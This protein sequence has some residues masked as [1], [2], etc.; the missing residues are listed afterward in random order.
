MVDWTQ[1]PVE[2]Q[3]LQQA[4]QYMAGRQQEVEQA[5]QAS[6]SSKSV[7][8]P[9]YRPP[10]A[11]FGL[12]ELGGLAGAVLGGAAGVPFG[13]A[14]V[15]GGSALGAGIGGAAGEATA[16]M[17]GDEKFS[18]SLITKAGL[19][20][21]AWDAGGNLVIKGAA[22]TLRFG[23]DKL[24]FTQK[25]IPDANQAAQQ[26]LEK[27]QSS[28]PLAART[29]SN[30]DA[31]LEGL[32]YTP[33]T[34][35]IFK[36]KQ[37]EIQ[38]ALRA[39]QK[40]VLKQFTTSPE[41]ETALRSGTSAQRASGE[42]L[43]NFIKQGEQALGEA[44]RPE[45]QKIFSAAPRTN[46]IETTTGGMPKVSTFGLNA[47]AS[48]QLADPLALTKGQES[49]LKEIKSLPSSVDFDTLHRIRSR[50]LAE[51]RDKY[52]ANGTEKDSLA[53]KTITSL[54]S[55]I[56][57]ALDFSADKTLPRELLNQY[58]QVTKTYREGIQ[59][60]QT[61]AVQKAL[62][63]NPEEVGATLF[64]AGNETPIQQLYKSVAAAGTLSGKSSKE[65]LDSLRVGYLDA[66]T[67]TPENMLKFAKDLEQNKNMQNTFNLLFGGT[68]QKDAIMAMNEAAKK[69]LIE[70]S[71]QPGLRGRT[72]YAIGG[73]GAAGSTVALAYAF[74]LSPEQ[75][76][77]AKDNLIG[78]G[79]SGASLVLSQRQLAK[80]M[81]DP[82]GAKAV[83]YLSNAKDRLKSPSAFT[84]LVI[85]P[86]NN[87]LGPSE[88]ELFTPTGNLN[89]SDV[90]VEK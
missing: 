17:L 69:G 88:T 35:D 9:D 34:F 20:E 67:H 10:R 62:E 16:Q 41:F 73:L 13:P 39:G 46:L 4:E 30:F 47:W 25:D 84:K 33:A 38:D 6:E 60:L 87:I 83:T 77:R 11:A 31:A 56:D 37:Q 36:R 53:S 28:L 14:G 89:W 8:S 27:Q 63:K 18:P 59:A 2:G 66:M 64:A 86:I 19:E 79:L 42:V 23:A 85:E 45:Y 54:V 12:Q 44:V 26:F 81:L 71:Y 5:A 7:L 58:K 57:E 24:G 22:K 50:W 52:A 48:G 15:I 55:K 51:N 70:P 21:A 3:K 61:D 82:K 29:G 65:I 80:V 90:P 74:A 72:G 78:V 43:Q 49:I 32:V 1:V 75:Q 40:D 76:Q 68:P